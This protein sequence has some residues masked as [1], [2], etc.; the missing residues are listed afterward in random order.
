MN[1]DDLKEQIKKIKKSGGE[2]LAVSAYAGDSRTMQNDNFE[3]IHKICES[4]NIWFHIDACHG[5]AL[6]FSNKLKHKLKGIELADSVTLD[7]HKVLMVP[8]PNS[9]VLFK[10]TKDYV[11]F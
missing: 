4:N 5:S 3:E 6:L 11:F 1:L 9:I 2:I 7:P 8:Y 10:N